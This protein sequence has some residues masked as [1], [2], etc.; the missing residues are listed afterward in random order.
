MF[1]QNIS[2]LRQKMNGFLKST[3]KNIR[4]YSTYK[5]LPKVQRQ[6]ID[7]ILRVDHAGLSRL[8]FKSI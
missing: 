4:Y 6:L 1:D 2:L 8:N 7:R 5:S 3:S